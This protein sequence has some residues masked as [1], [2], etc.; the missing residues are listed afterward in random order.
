[1]KT[2]IVEVS[3]MLAVLNPDI[4]ARASCSSRGRLR[5]RAPCSPELSKE[6]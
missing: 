1:M 6:A 2:N 4:A 3:A 5:R